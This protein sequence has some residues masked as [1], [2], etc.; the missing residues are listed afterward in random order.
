[1]TVAGLDFAPG[2]AGRDK[3]LRPE[4]LRVERLDARTDL[5]AL[6]SVAY[7]RCTDEQ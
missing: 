7:E 3:V 2:R 1:M 4:Q 5:Y 6:G